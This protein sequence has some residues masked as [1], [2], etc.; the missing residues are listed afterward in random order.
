MTPKTAQQGRLRRQHGDR[1]MMCRRL[2]KIPQPVAVS[3]PSGSI[4]DTSAGQRVERA[5]VAVE[6]SVLDR[7]RDVTRVDPGGAVEV[8]DGAGD[9]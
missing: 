7:L 4:E 8:G 6:I 9:L 5:V 1:V 2:L 3:T